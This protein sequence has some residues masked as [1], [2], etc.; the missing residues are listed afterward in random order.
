MKVPFKISNMK[1][2]F[3]ILFLMALM[4]TAIAQSTSPRFGTLKNQDNTG[5]ILTYGYVGV[6]DAAGND[7]YVVKPNAYETIYKVTLIDSLT[8]TQPT[9][10]KC[11]LGDKMTIILNAA[12]GTPK[13]KFSGDVWINAGTAKLSTKV[14]GVLVMIF[15]GAKWVEVSRVIQ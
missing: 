10:T 8:F 9:V 11:S 7:S 2:I 1:K 5:R 12:S 13:L 4:L 3:S 14:R 6:T 15:D